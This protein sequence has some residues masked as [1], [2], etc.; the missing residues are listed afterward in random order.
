MVLDDTTDV[1]SFEERKCLAD[2]LLW[3]ASDPIRFQ[4]WWRYERQNWTVYV[5]S[6]LKVYGA[7]TLHEV[8]QRI[9]NKN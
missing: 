9:V 1:L 8:L 4:T 3:N 5:Y 6:V 2:A 7:G